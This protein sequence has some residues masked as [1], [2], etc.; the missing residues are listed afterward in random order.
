MVIM[1]INQSDPNKN[2]NTK[3]KLFLL[4]SFSSPE[5]T[6]EQNTKGSTIHDHMLQ[7]QLNDKNSPL[8]RI[9]LI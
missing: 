5:M 8:L 7:K 4:I 6:E 9:N 1:I 2:K 3:Q